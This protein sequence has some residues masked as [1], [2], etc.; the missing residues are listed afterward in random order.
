ML[1]TVASP[2]KNW[3]N[4]PAFVRV[5]PFVI[6]LL[7]TYCQGV[8]GETTRYWMYAL[9]TLVGFWFV[10]TIRPVVLEM[11]WVFSWQA[12]IAGM[13]VFAFWVGL[14]GHYPTLDELMQKYLCPL[15]K[16]A[17]LE[18]W[19]PKSTTPTTWNPNAQF[20]DG[21]ALARICIVVRIVGST[22]VVPP[23][24]EVFY[25]SFL[26]RY[27]IKPEFLAVALGTFRIGAFTFTSAVFGFTHHQWLAGILCGFV[28]Q[29]LV[30]SKNRLG[31]AM[32]AHAITNLLLGIWVVWK[33]AWQFW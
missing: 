4:Y 23:L 11:K 22:F 15:L 31:D 9:K 3:R 8:G 16:S 12:I 27:I 26:Y 29:G 20:G 30:I 18:S 19:C 21:S 6:F 2:D 24:E 32:A 7:L 33:G 1:P 10:L 5:F 17:G 25:R 14:D 13:G 28:Y